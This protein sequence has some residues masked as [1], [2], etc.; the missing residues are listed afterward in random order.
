MDYKQNDDIKKNDGLVPVYEIFGPT[1]QGEGLHAGRRCMFIRTCLCNDHCSWCDSKFAWST[2]DAKWMNADQMFEAV[3]NK[4][5]T[6][7]VLTGG[8]PCIH[9]G[10]APFVAMC[11]DH[12][13]R[14]EVE[15]QGGAYPEWLRD[16][17][18]I[19]F[20]PKAPSAGHAVADHRDSISAWM[21]SGLIPTCIIKIPVFDDNDIKFAKETFDMFRDIKLEFKLED[22]IEFYLSVGNKDTSAKGSIADTILNDYL[23]LIEY[24][25]RHSEGFEDV[26]ILPQIHTLIWGNKGGV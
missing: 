5:C 10:F 19:T 14:V 24:I 3:N 7:V 22:R 15:T 21:R 23:E 4:G 1:I 6:T 8:N 13:M 17:D 9:S 12:G 25:N 16:V 11:Q 20:S 26:A 2:E 18:L